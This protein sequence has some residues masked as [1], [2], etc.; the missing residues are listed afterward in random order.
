VRAYA[1]TVV[2]PRHDGKRDGACG[3]GLTRWVAWRC[4]GRH[5][6]QPLSSCPPRSGRGVI[7]F[8]G[9]SERP[10][11]EGLR[12][13]RRGPGA[14]LTCLAA[15]NPRT[16]ATSCL[17]A[18]WQPRG[19]PRIAERWRLRRAGRRR[20]TARCRTYAAAL[21]RWP[22]T[23]RAHRS[24]TRRGRGGFPRLEHCS[25]RASSPRPPCLTPRHRRA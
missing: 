12:H 9:P 19:P 21:H 22:L 6:H 24:T 4:H 23:D 13:R 10:L 18:G 8:M 15:P 25:P 14:P 5:P 20:A 7:L 2:D 11:A 1:C 3:A 17:A 16:M